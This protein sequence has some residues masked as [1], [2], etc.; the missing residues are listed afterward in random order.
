MKKMIIVDYLNNNLYKSNIDKIN[1][2][3]KFEDN[4]YNDKNLDDNIKNKF[5]LTLIDEFCKTLS[6]KQKYI[7]KENPYCKESKEMRNILRIQKH[8]NKKTYSNVFEFLTSSNLN[9]KELIKKFN[10][11]EIFSKYKSGDV[12]NPKNYRYFQ[13]HTNEIKII[14]NYIKYMIDIVLKDDYINTDI[15]ICKIKAGQN[16]KN[17]RRCI[18][19]N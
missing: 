8:L 7:L 18:L 6:N 5:N 15:F 16:I 3:Y 10:R 12:I 11:T 13:N 1:N 4:I 17:C 2:L 9:Q 19:L 14:C